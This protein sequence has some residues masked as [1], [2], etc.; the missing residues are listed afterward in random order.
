[1]R[2]NWLDRYVDDLVPVLGSAEGLR[3][4]MQLRHILVH[5]ADERG[6]V[7]IGFQFVCTWDNDGFGALWR[8]GKVEEWGTWKDGEPKA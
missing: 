8:D 7:T 1:M 3:D 4:L 5:P 2:R 6:R